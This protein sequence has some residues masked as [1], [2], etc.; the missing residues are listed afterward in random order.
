MESSV[1]KT[2]AGKLETMKPGSLVFPSDFKGLGAEGAIKMAFS[3]LTKQNKL[4]R[5]A[6]GIYVVPRFDPLMGFM[7]PALEDIAEAIARRDHARI[8]PAGTF[9][10]H[11][12]GLSTQVPMR[13]VYLTDGAP[14]RINIGKGSIKFKA[15]TPRKLS[16]Q[17]N[18]SSLII[19]A[20][21]ELGRKNVTPE[22]VEKIR[23]LLKHET[24]EL[25]T[26]DL[27]MST[28]WVSKLL[29]DIMKQ[30]SADDRT[31]QS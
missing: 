20:L 23:P 10:L 28:G 31:N 25:L 29:S 8:R 15:T 2:I 19:Q 9:A 16:L 24:T 30:N 7:Y 12:L 4:K 11:K 21:E 18:V 5:M 22:I 14:R 13:L 1:H 3:R 26:N 27:K 17:G 6:N